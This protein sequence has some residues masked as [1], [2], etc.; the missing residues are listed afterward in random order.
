MD[1]DHKAGD[2]NP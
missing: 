2:W 1:I